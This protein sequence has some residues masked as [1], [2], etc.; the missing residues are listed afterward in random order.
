[1]KKIVILGLLAFVALVLAE[2][3]G[4]TTFS[5]GTAIG[6]VDA[7][8]DGISLWGELDPN[9]LGILLLAASGSIMAFSRLT[10]ALEDRE[11]GG[12]ETQPPN[13]REEFGTP[14]NESNTRTSRA[15]VISLEDVYSVDELNAAK[16]TQRLGI[17]FH[18]KTI[19]DIDKMRA[20]SGLSSRG[21][22]IRQALDFL[23]WA[24]VHKK[25][26]AR[27]VA[28]YDDGYTEPYHLPRV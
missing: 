7:V 18:A 16:K 17:Q 4:A 1:M 5:T 22:L 21:G 23:K 9:S 11:D 14:D 28:Q 19:E 24:F 10:G 25:A 15:K 27:I 6:K 12:S 2:E 13:N 26:G 8:G 20:I 3:A